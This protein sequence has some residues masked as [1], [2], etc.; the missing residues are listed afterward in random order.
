[1]GAQMNFQET[2]TRTAVKSVL[3]RIVATL[4][5]WGSFYYFTGDIGQ[6]TKIT[7]FAAI[8]GIIAYYIFERIFNYIQ[9]GKIITKD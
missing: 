4:I 3:W 9:W 5:T 6:S 8:V 1:V 2:K 7:I